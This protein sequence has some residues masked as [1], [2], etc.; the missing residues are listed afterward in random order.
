VRPGGAVGRFDLAH[1]GML[2]RAAKR[3]LA[4]T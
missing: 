4:L 1:A 3:Q 2:S